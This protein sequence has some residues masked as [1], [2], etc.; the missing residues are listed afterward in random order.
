MEKILCYSVN[1]LPKETPMNTNKY[2]LVILAVSLVILVLVLGQMVVSY[3]QAGIVEQSVDAHNSMIAYPGQLTGDNGNAV[4]DGSYELSFALYNDAV[5]GDKVWSEI[6]TGIAVQNGAFAVLL[7]SVNPLPETAFSTKLWLGV[8]VRGP[9]DVNFTVLTPRQLLNEITYAN[10]EVT[11]NTAGTC[12]HDHMFEQWVG[13]TASYG[14]RV[15]NTGMGDG[16]S[17]VTTSTLSTYA[18]VYASNIA[19]TGQGAGLYA[20]TNSSTGYGVHGY[21]Y[22]GTAIYGVSSSGV[23][24]SGSSSSNDGLVGTTTAV[25]KSGIFG[26]TEN[27][28]GVTG[29]STNFFGMQAVGNDATGDDALGDL[30]LSG[31]R[32]EILTNERLNLTSNWNVNVEI[33]FDN[34]TEQTG[35]FRIYGNG[36]NAE[37][38][39]VDDLGNMMAIG[40]KS[41]LVQTDNYGGRLLYAIEGTEVW[42]EDIGS[43]VLAEGKVEVVID[44][45]YAQTVNLDDYQVFITP[46]S[47]VPVILYVAEKSPTSF[48]V[49]GVTLDGE[50]AACDFDY[51]I[52]AKRLGYET[53]RLQQP[54]VPDGDPK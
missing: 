40:A 7:G 51:R 36:S 32:G 23:G 9:Q 17:G 49:Q 25:G 29:Q 3:A 43:A 54:A 39:S 19:T 10:Q 45:V 46:V 27:G 44:P 30:W 41:A 50:P 20:R 48:I 37:V 4:A 8:S 1:K 47:N 22:A 13:S 16:I 42:F 31:T 33:D 6:Q 26:Y 28:Y 24:V 35:T 5:F 11:S 14:F 18:G 2:K 34:T 12:A 21:N 38:F 52:I 15:V 53:V